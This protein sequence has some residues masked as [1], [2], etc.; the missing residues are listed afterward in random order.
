MFFFF[1]VSEDQFKLCFFIRVSLLVLRLF[2]N[3]AL[4]ISGRVDR[5]SATE[6]VDLG[7]IPARV[8]P[9]TIKLV[10]TASLHEVQRLAKAAW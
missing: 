7:W 4:L 10:F 2:V 5:A 8:K 6:T 3:V 9:K 1:F